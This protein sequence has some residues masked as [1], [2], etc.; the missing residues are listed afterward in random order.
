[1]VPPVPDLVAS[2]LPQDMQVFM[3]ILRDVCFV[4]LLFSFLTRMASGLAVENAGRKAVEE[5]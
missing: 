5:Q 3:M 4:E 1:M 2:L